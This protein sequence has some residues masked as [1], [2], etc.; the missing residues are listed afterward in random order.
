MESGKAAL[1]ASKK[2]ASAG[3]AEAEAQISMKSEE[4]KQAQL[5]ITEKMAELNVADTQ[6]QQNLALLQTA[7]AEAQAQ[8]TQLE[9]DKAEYDQARITL[10]DLNL[11]LTPEQKEELEERIAQLE[12][13]VGNGIYEATYKVGKWSSVRID[14]P[15]EHIQS[16]L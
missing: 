4:L 7:K 14:L 9:A 11:P 6:I 3:L 16:F 8:L 15:S 10:D 5:E 1:E 2:Q 12:S 13:V